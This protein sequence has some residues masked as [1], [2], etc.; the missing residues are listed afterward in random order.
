MKICFVDVLGL[1]FDGSTLD[2]RGLGGSESAMILMAKELAKI[3]FK[4]TVYNDCESDDCNPGFYDEVHYQPLRAVEFNHT[5]YDIMVGSR[6]IAPF[7]GQDLISN[8]KVQ[9]LPDFT[10][11]YNQSKKKIL[12]MHDTFCDGDHL[13]EHLVDVGRIDEIFTLSDFQTSYISNCDHGKRRNFEVL[14]NKIFQTRNGIVK[15]IDWVDIKQKDPNLFVYNASVTKG[16]IPLVEKIWPELKKK[17]PDAK[18]TVIGGYYRFKNSK[19]DEQEFKWHDLVVAHP[20]VNFTGI[21]K[22]DEI[23]EI[24][25]KAS[26]MIYP[27]AF[28]ETFGISALESLAY[29]TPLITNTFGALEE[30]AID[31]ACYKIPYAIEPNVLFPFIN[32][33]WQENA[34]INTAFH[35]YMNGYLHQQKMYACNQVQDVCTWDTV[36]LQ[37]KQHFYHILGEYLPIEDYRKVSQINYKVSKVFGRRFTNLETLQEPRQEQKKI[38][39]ISP[40]YNCQNYIKKCVLSVAAQDY[41]NYIHYVVNDASTDDTCLL[42]HDTVDNLP[43]E[44]SYKFKK[45]NNAEHT[46]SAVYAQIDTIREFHENDDCIIMLLDGDDWLVNNPNIFHMYN[47]LYHA[48]AEFTYG[49]CWSVVDNIPL[50]AQEYPPEVKKN[51]TYRKYKFN[52]QMPYTHLRTFSRQLLDNIDYSV[53]KDEDGNW[54]KAGGDNAVFYNLIEAADPDKVV[55][56]PEVVYHY[57]DAHPNNDYKINSEEQTLNANKIQGQSVKKKILIAIPTAKYIEPQTFKSIYDLQVPD[58]YETTFQY[59]FGYNIEQIRNLIADWT[60][61][62][63]DYLFAVDSDITFQPDTLIKL[64]SH[65]KDI[66]TG[67]YR[68][69]LPTETLEIY[70]KDLRNI[71]YD[72]ITNKLFEIGGCGFGCVLVKADVFKKI[73][74]PQFKYHSALDHKD[75]FS[76]DVD[77]CKKARES[78]STIWVDKSIVCGHIGSTTFEVYTGPTIDST[79][80]DSKIDVIEERLSELGSMKLLPQDHVNFL[81]KIKEEG[82]DPKVV[83]DIGACVLHWSKEARQIWPDS[84]IIPMEAMSEVGSIY[85]QNGFNTYFAGHPLSDENKMVDFWENLEHPGGN[86]YYKENTEL[87]PRAKELFDKP[88]PKQAYTLDYVVKSMELPLP[89]LIKMDVQGAELD[90][91]KGATETLKSCNHL[92][93]ELQHMDYN[94]GAPKHQEVINYLAKLGFKTDGMFCGSDLGVDGDYYFWRD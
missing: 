29:N 21:I 82:F 48:G 38:V 93:L 56:V 58:G 76:E 51:C 34:F 68:Q 78:G 86:S 28:P 25:A 37:W 7:A 27:A 44:L 43:E 24:L 14:K 94:L 20:D 66:V 77:F 12:W 88:T 40:A 75:T 46:G 60:I 17:I 19:P 11:L 4:V 26:Y 36:A 73:N 39:V 70:D 85:K 59:F 42:W 15:H 79:Y 63:F 30:T 13:V 52:W 72:A 64:L 45:I 90:I 57:N 81:K 10:D 53:F 87:S 35:A 67:I 83:Y 49:S 9:N 69:R 62:G 61:K 16:M 22:Q 33:D 54:F 6:S 8:S 84:N 89:D 31:A 47:N 32:T 23:A 74:Y 3:G 2:K 91:I 5:D 71:S 18:L 1:P 41:D 80:T 92:I 55:C 50:I 65:D